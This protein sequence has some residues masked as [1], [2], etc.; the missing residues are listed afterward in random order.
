MWQVYIKEL[1][2]LL[3]DKKTLF[4]IIALPLVIFPVIFGFMG[5]L[6]A[7]A[8]ISHSEKQ[9]RY[10]IVN[11]DAAPDF[12]EVLFYHNDFEYIDLP[13][14]DEASYR[15]AIQSDKVDM[16]IVVDDNFASRN[17]TAQP[18]TWQLFYNGANIIAGSR[19]KF[20]DALQRYVERLQQQQWQQ[21]GVDL[22]TFEV[23]KQPI[24]I[25]EYD[26]ADDRESLGEKIGGFIPYLLI[27]LCLTGAMYPAI[28]L[29]AGEKERGTIE[30]L[31]LTPTSRFS[32]VMGK[33]LCIFTTA[34]MTA[35]ITLLSMLLWSFIVGNVMSVAEVENVLSAIS[36]TDFIMVLLLLMPI[37][38]IFAALLL[39]ISIYASS[40]KEAQNYMGPLTILVIFPVIVGMTPGIVLNNT[41][42]LVPVANV[43]LAMKE[44]LK[45][46]MDY[47]LLVP[48]FL[49]T[50]VFAVASICFCVYWFNKESVL[51]R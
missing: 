40:Y 23:F 28:D 4:F 12:A 37:C 47:A 19:L 32:L 31:L 13:L 7:K 22:N 41:W 26:T 48:I 1:I 16:V 35:V 5:F 33:F 20:D 2:E 15:Q 6:G 39:A 11:A 25:E 29:G 18:S 9:V 50:G 14:T 42:A 45:G 30:T 36:I 34:I 43:A 49:S 51:F 44:L 38:A 10:V 17:A 8:A 24:D 27:P 46:T 3:R 21:F